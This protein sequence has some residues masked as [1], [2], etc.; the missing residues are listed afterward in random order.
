MASRNVSPK[1]LEQSF[2]SDWRIDGISSSD[3]SRIRLIRFRIFRMIFLLFGVQVQKLEAGATHPTGFRFFE[4]K[5][6][7]LPRT[8]VANN[9]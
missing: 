2:R 6:K 8:F 7:L 1:Y 3:D 5:R 9:L 4:L